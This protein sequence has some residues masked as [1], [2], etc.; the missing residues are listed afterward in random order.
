MGVRVHWGRHSRAQLVVVVFFLEAVAAVVAVV[1]A[2]NW[3]V[4]CS[5]ACAARLPALFCRYPLLDLC[6]DKKS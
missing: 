6:S 1:F 3:R 5:K 2:Q 4:R